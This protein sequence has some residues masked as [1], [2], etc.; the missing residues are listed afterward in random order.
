MWE[1][2]SSTKKLIKI[3]DTWV[4]PSLIEYIIGFPTHVILGMCSGAK[5]EIAESEDDVI[6]R[7]QEAAQA[8]KG[9]RETTW[10]NLHASDAYHKG[11]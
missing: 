8:N 3:A 9:K 4:D 2:W 10:Q 11:R 1:S 7:L 5:L 6:A